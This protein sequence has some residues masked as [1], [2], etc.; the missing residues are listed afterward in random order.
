MKGTGVE[1]VKNISKEKNLKCLKL[2][3]KIKKKTKLL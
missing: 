1:K 3:T 2:H